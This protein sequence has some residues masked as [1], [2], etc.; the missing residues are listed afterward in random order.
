MKNK[1]VTSVGII[2]C[3]QQYSCRFAYAF[4]VMSLTLK[5]SKADLIDNRF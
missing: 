5:L 4:T 2:S 3:F 1:M